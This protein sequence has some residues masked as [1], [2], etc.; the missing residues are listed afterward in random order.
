MKWT[1]E[2]LSFSH[3][4]GERVTSF[5]GRESSDALVGVDVAEPGSHVAGILGKVHAPVQGEIEIQD[6][7]VTHVSKYNDTASLLDIHAGGDTFA[8]VHVPK[9][10]SDFKLSD[11]IVT[12]V[13]DYY[14]GGVHE[15][16]V[17][18]HAASGSFFFND[19]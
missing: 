8:W 5:Q 2:A 3:I 18:L 17:T 16:R 10:W 12:G 1:G 13:Y 6:G 7:C 19:V 9:V 14:R 4:T 11:E 15:K